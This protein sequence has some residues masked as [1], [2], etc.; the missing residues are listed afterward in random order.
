LNVTDRFPAS[1]LALRGVFSRQGMWWSGFKAGLGSNLFRLI[2]ELCT[3]ERPVEPLVVFREDSLKGRTESWPNR[4][5][6][7][8]K[9][10][11]FLQ[12]KINTKI[13][14]KYVLTNSASVIIL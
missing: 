7:F 10:V 8:F 6:L 11:V 2:I 12:L 13:N 4:P 5:A 14:Y 3:L 9:R 1:I